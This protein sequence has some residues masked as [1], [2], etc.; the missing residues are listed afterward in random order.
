MKNFRKKEQPDS[1]SIIPNNNPNIYVAMAWWAEDD[2]I[3]FDLTPII[4]WKITHRKDRVDS[5]P[6][7]PNCSLSNTSDYAILDKLTGSW[8]VSYDD[9]CGSD[10]ES[11]KEELRKNLQQTDQVIIE[12]ID[13]FISKITPTSKGVLRKNGA[14]GFT[15]EALL[16]AAG[17]YCYYLFTIK[18]AIQRS[19]RKTDC[20][21]AEFPHWIADATSI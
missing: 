14:T 16:S 11:M 4:A 1:I 21:D 18:N 7:L 10:E 5:I 9:P 17:D 19:E 15:D 8:S 12:N 2:S 6:I 20:F 3:G 13:E